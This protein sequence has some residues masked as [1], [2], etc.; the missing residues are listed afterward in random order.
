MLLCMRCLLTTLYFTKFLTHIPVGTC[1]KLYPSQISL[2]D[3]T[4][5][6]PYCVTKAPPPGK[7]DVRRNSKHMQRLSEDNVRRNEIGHDVNGE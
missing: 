3:E 7:D 1:H 5:P 6:P 2:A 4:G